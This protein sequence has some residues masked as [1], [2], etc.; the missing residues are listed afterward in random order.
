MNN[1]DSNNTSNMNNFNNVETLDDI[2]LQDNSENKQ[3]TQDQGFIKPVQQVQNTNQLLESVPKP[4][5]MISS[6]SS[7]SILTDDLLEEYVGNNYEKISKRKVNFA[8][9]FFTG[10]YFIYRK[11]ILEGIL[12]S[13]ISLIAFYSILILSPIIALIIPPIISIVLCF[14]FNKMYLNSCKKK[15]DNIK[16]K[17]K[18]K[19][20]ADLKSICVRK[21]GTSLVLAIVISI[22]I[23]AAVTL[24]FN[25]VAP[26]NFDD[27]RDKVGN[28]IV[29]SGNTSNNNNNS[30]SGKNKLDVTYDKDVVLSDLIDIGYLQ[31]FT[32]TEANSDSSYDY[33]KQLT[34]DNENSYCT[35][36]L[37]VVKN[38]TSSVELINE[39]ANYYNASDTISTKKTN[40]GNT[41]NLFT[42]KEEKT[43][44]YSA[45][46]DGQHVYLFKY[47]MDSDVPNSANVY[48]IGILNSINFK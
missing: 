39:M 32:P 26:L 31:I 23:S 11:M 10:T 42:V 19:S 45:T 5:I 37:S 16:L 21:G 38:Y 36:N 46:E 25:T 43:T 41:W 40:N 15:I 18:N 4:D 27:I 30:N 13:A 12:L 44:I 17:N 28:L 8:A 20:V 24:I 47:V 48:H 33:K 35:F 22:F 2:D 34:P 9:F 29:R 7:N 14:I 3:E 1:N 6:P